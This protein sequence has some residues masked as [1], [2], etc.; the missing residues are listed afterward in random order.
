MTNKTLEMLAVALVTAGVIILTIKSDYFFF[1]ETEEDAYTEAVKTIPYGIKLI[2]YSDPRY[3]PKDAV[4]THVLAY[5]SPSTNTI[6][7]IKGNACLLKH[8]IR[9]SKGD[10]THEGWSKYLMSCKL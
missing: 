7:T 4:E 1:L 3:Y 8:E 5:F 9:H 2:E 6:H 10:H